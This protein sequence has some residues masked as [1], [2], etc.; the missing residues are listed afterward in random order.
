L[1]GSARDATN[2]AILDIDGQIR[3]RGGNP[4][5]DKLL[6]V[7]ASA[8]TNGLATW[9]DALF[10]QVYW[11]EA[12]FG[13]VPDPS[14]APPG[15]TPGTYVK[16]KVAVATTTIQSRITGSCPSTN[17]AISAVAQ[18][19]TVSCRSLV[20]GVTTANGG[21]TVTGGGVGP[22][23]LSI[24]AGAG[25]D[26]TSG[27]LQVKPLA[28]G[29][30]L[31]ISNNYLK[32]AT[33]TPAIDTACSGNNVYWKYNT[34]SGK[35]DCSASLG[36]RKPGESIM[37]LK[38][39]GG[40]TPDACPSGWTN[41][42][43]GILGYYTEQVGGGYHNY[44]R[45]CKRTVPADIC[46]TMYLTNSSG[47]IGCSAVSIP[48]PPACPTANGW[49]EANINSVYTPNAG[50]YCNKVRVCSKCN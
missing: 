24:N 5:Q 1:A 45:I 37:Y 9:S 26:T 7:D 20:S 41:F 8:A 3:I 17:S 46:Q 38:R 16:E 11:L 23:N 29:S 43:I 48:N 4:G 13:I 33:T 31:V 30:G 14:F 6:A 21:L 18:D 12:G 39:M 10:N 36:S 27:P 19:G 35:W 50:N 44:V 28:I 22:I 15:G 34:S 47:P 42:P 40:Y 32:F 49:S 25:L 2:P